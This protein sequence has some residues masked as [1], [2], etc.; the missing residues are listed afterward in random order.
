MQRNDQ[1]LQVEETMFAHAHTRRDQDNLKTSDREAWSESKIGR[2]YANQASTKFA[3]TVASKLEAYDPT[4]GRI[5]N[6]AIS[7]LVE[8]RLE[9]EVMSHLFTKTLYNL[10]PLTHRKRLRKTTLC[11]KVGEA[12]HDEMRIRHFSEVKTRKNLLKVIF[13]QFD[14]RL[15]PRAWRK[16]SILAYFSAEQISWHGW[17][18]DQK[19]MIGDALLTWFT[20]S[21]GLVTHTKDGFV[22]PVP[23]LLEHVSEALKSRVLEFMLYQPMLTNPVPWSAEDNLF[24]GGYLSSNVR[25]YPLVKGTGKKDHARLMSMDWSQVIPAINALQETGWRV[26][27]AILSALEWTVARGGGVAGL[28]ASDPLPLPPKPFGYKVDKEITEAHNVV[29]FL[30]HSTNRE[31]ISKRLMLQ[32]TIA[33]ANAFKDHERITMPHNLDSR[34][35]AYPLPVFLNPQGPDATKS[36]LEFSEGKPIDTEDALNWLCIAG[37]NAYGNDKVALSERVEWVNSNKQMIL[38]IAR[39]YKTD[40]RWHAASEP[41]QFLRFAFEFAAFTEVGFGFVSHMVC[42]VDATCSGIQHYSM[43]LKDS[44]GGRSVNLIPGLPRQDIYGDVAEKTIEKLFRESNQYPVECKNL[45]SFGIDRKITKRITMVVPYSASF[46]ACMTYTRES[47]QDKIAEGHPC[48]WDI[49]NKDEHSRHTVLLSKLIWESISEVVIKSS[50][51]M[52][53]LTKAAQAHTKHVNKHVQGSVYD[54]RMTWVTPD[55]FEV[56]HYRA[57]VKK[58]QIATYLDGKTRKRMQINVPTDTLSSK[59]M[60]KAVAPNFIHS[61]DACLMRMA[62]VK[63]LEQGITSYGM[64][65]DSFGVHASEMSVFLN[66]CVKP[67]FIEMYQ[68]NVLEDFKSHL[69][70]DLDLPALPEQGDLDQQGV[71]DSEF[72]FS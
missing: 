66:K 53:W 18:Q 22:E 40:L 44:V 12:L 70:P 37:A 14:R 20:D 34:G 42:P 30:V 15:Y 62:I 49:K 51:A 58:K 33:I 56:V 52:H 60:S 21:T 63:G 43:A 3:H 24:K 7:L 45:L 13:K 41:F 48:P 57:D 5:N 32:T 27:K 23:A 28:P 6:R 39:N 61:M 71:M 25:P 1:Q 46:S 55:G 11:M 35:R 38:E 26:N 16:R 69:H 31:M 65:H 64:V 10:A 36:L 17:T 59:D 50:E 19:A 4:L 72:F 29:C 2:A 68:T 8:S 47:I 67:A 54:K 9:C